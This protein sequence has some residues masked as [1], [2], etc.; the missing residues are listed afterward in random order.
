QSGQ[1]QSIVLAA[2]GND[3]GDYSVDFSYK[4]VVHDIIG[5]QIDAFNGTSSIP[6]AG[7]RYIL[8]T[9][10]ASN[11]I[12]IGTINFEI[13]DTVWVAPTE[14]P[15]YN[16]SLNNVGTYISQNGGYINGTVT[17]EAT[18]SANNI[19]L[20]AILHDFS[21][22]IVGASVANVGDLPALGKTA[23]K[24]TLPVMDTRTANSIDKS[25]TEVSYEVIKD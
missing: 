22:K 9:G 14:T 19:D 25:K 18:S 5:G 23:F 21:G 11:A 3:S 4:M 7:M 24:I 16:L 17:N 6:A 15:Q 20:L 8:F 1:D 13:T 2:L 10:I 12:N